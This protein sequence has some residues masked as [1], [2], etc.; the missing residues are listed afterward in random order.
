MIHG[1]ILSERAR[2][3][4]DVTALVEVRTGQRFSYQELQARAEACAG[5]LS[6]ELGFEVGDRFSILSN[7]RVEFIDLLFAAA[8]TGMVLVPLNTRLAVPEL[9]LIVQDSGA[10][11]LFFDAAHQK[12]ALKLADQIPDL[13]LIAL[14]EKPAGISW[15]YADALAQNLGIPFPRV[16]VSPDHPQCLLY[17]SGT[18]GK[19]KGVIIP[20]R[21]IVW[22]GFA[23]AA[24]WQLS[25]EDV[26]PVFT[27]IYHAGGLGAFLIPIFTV[28]GRIILHES[29]DAGEVWETIDQEGCTVVLGVPTIWSMLADHPGFEHSD[30]KSV[31]WFISG[32]APLPRHLIETYQK[33]G[34]VLRQ[35]YGMTEVGV[36][37]FTMTDEDALAKQG[38]IGRPM[39]YLETRVVD[40]ENK[41]LGPGEVGELC[42]RGPALSMGYWNQPE[43][44]AASRDEDGFFHT[45]DMVR[46]DED[47][48]FYI[49]G[50][51]K[52][53]L[54]S[55][56]V[57]V[58]PAE[59]ENELLRH[60]DLAD[61]AVVGVPDSTWGELGVAFVVP[62]AGQNPSS[63][64]LTSF[65]SGR[66]AKFK[67]PRK[68]VFLDEL[69]RTSY[70]K[71]VKGELRKVFEASRSTE[72]T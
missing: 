31:R 48:F 14:D 50:R 38:S 22:N 3:S 44:T 65:L 25:S 17:T 13:V 29:F 59:I 20:H 61:V 15:A 5:F 55:G 26:S 32:G 9:E 34:I 51:G 27:P 62:R 72:S 52:D 56:G 41:I 18:T 39:L 8:K 4:P 19:P 6:G 71:V 37:C 67:I 28:G 54:I 49:A 68:W 69:P 21:M 57:N 30:L 53:M 70:G 35:G 66:L 58:Y 43:V 40:Q 36:N 11:A 45:G 33:R 12:A 1:D 63:D 10:R 64:E 42:F 23:T 16:P 46:F 7:N 24:A 47:G 2:I 60:P